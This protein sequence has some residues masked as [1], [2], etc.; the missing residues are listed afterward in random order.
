MI[1]SILVPT[2]TK[3]VGKFFTPLV[4][5]LN[6]Q[7]ADIGTN[8]VEILGLLDNYKM[9]IGKKRNIF[10]QMSSGKYTLFVDDDDRVDSNFIREVL[11]CISLNT[12][13]DCIVYD[14]LCVINKCRK[15]HS[16]FGIEYE[17]TKMAPWSIENCSI[18]NSTPEMWY[19]KPSHNMIWKSSI[20]KSCIFPDQ[21]AG[22]DFAWVS[23]A[24]P[25]IKNQSRIDKIIYYYDVV[26]DKQY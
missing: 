2:T 22:E 11:N 10:L 13:T 19:G 4:S 8:D 7:I 23:Q 21:N 26:L 25:K 20:S 17:Y 14:M 3:R 12:D 5:E 24:W 9:S 6:N 18:K 1:L 15:I 16:K